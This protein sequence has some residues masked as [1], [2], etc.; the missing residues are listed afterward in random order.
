MYYKGNSQ[1]SNIIFFTSYYITSNQCYILGQFK[2]NKYAY[3]VLSCMKLHAYML[4]VLEIV[5]T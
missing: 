2:Y 1:S 3:Y 5:F 4:K